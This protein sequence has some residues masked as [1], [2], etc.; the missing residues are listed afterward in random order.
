MSRSRFLRG[1]NLLLAAL[2]LGTWG[3]VFLLRGMPGA[4]AWALAVLV[5]APAGLVLAL[6]VAVLLLTRAVKRRPVRQL[7]GT[8][9]LSAVLALPVLV[10]TN[11]VPVAY[12]ASVERSAPSLAIPS[13]F[14]EDVVVGLGGDS[15]RTNRA[16]VI[17][18]SERWAYDLVADPYATGSERL[19]A[20][21]I[22]GMDVHSPVVGVVT[23]VG[24]GEADI[25]PNTEEFS[26]LAGNYI[27]IRVTVD[28]A[29]AY[30]VLA[31]LR[32]GTVGVVPGQQV[33]VG[34]LL[35]QVGNSGTSSEPHLHVHLQRQDPAR[36]P[37]PV[38]AE[39]LP[40]YFLRG[41]GDPAMPVAG[42][43][44]EA[45]RGSH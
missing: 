43:V 5:L 39:G 11:L 7:A 13:P 30:L 4:A 37:H 33:A 45:A 40:L 38:V 17:W 12:P 19:D 35:A 3:C 22:F 18:P 14:R 24:D 21:G 16:H 28:G 15:V 41:P 29:E 44:I 34:D 10:L 20:H 25:P 42:D 9:A 23:A 8:L 31:H 27:H 36:V 6:A 26:S 2:L 1:V 32:Q